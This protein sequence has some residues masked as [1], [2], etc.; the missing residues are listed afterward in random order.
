MQTVQLQL[1]IS[2]DILDK[3]MFILNNLPKNKV[4]LKI[5]DNFFASSTNSFNP[6]DFFGVTNSSK[7]EI[8]SYLRENSSEWDNVDDVALLHIEDSAKYVHDL[9]RE[10]RCN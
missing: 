3:V 7:A 4:K 2:R 5:I 9:R 1:D 6:R 8:D 10:K